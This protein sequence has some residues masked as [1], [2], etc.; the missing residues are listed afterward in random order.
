MAVQLDTENADRDLTSVVTVLTHTPS[1][2]LP[3]RCQGLILLGDGVKDLCGTGGDYELTVSIGGNIAEPGPQVIVFGTSTRSTVWTSEFPVPANAEVLLRVKSP[4]A[5][6]IDVDV[7]A[8]L[9]DVD[10]LTAADKTGHVLASTGLDEIPVTAPAGVAASFSEM[11]VQLWRRFFKKSTLSATE[12]KTYADNG[13]A[14]LTTQAATDT[15][16][17]QTLGAAE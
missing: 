17:S 9:Y 7:T 10:S 6:D 12:L 4:N 2:S 13:T 11:L 1:A 15:G 3:L 8:Y 16:V 14:V 5:T